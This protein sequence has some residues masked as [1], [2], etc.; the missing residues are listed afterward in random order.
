MCAVQNAKVAH[1]KQSLSGGTLKYGWKSPTQ[2]Y[3][4]KELE[5]QW[6]VTVCSQSTEVNGHDLSKASHEEAIDAFHKAEEP[7][8]V[9]VLRRSVKNSSQKMK[10]KNPISCTVATQTDEFIEN[11]M[12]YG[13]YDNEEEILNQHGVPGLYTPSSRIPLAFSPTNDMGLTDIEMSNAYEYNFE[14]SFESEQFNDFEYEEVTLHRASSEE[15][16]GL[17]LCYGSTD[18]DL[19]D[20]FISEIDP[21]SIAAQ[22]GRIKSGDQILQINGIDVHSRE[23]AIKLFQED[24]SDIT[25]LLGRQIQM[26]DGFLE[27]G[28][29][30]VLDDLH[31]DMLRQHPHFNPHL[32]GQGNDEEGATTDTATT[33]NSLTR[34]EKD[35]GVGRT[36]EST[37]NDE[38][39]E[40]EMMD[41][42]SSPGNNSKFRHYSDNS[43]TSNDT[44]ELEFRKNEISTQDCEKFREVLANR[45]AEDCSAKLNGQKE[46]SR[47]DSHSSLEQELA[48]LNKEMEHI[49]L[50]CQEI[51]DIHSNKKQLTI[52]GLGG[53]PYQSPRVVPRMGTRLDKLK[54]SNLANVDNGKSESPVKPIENIETPKHIETSSLERDKDT[55]YNTA[56]SSHRSTP[57]TLELSAFE[58][59]T[60]SSMLH[61]PATGKSDSSSK[62]SKKSDRRSERNHSRDG[63]SHSDSNKSANEGKRRS[64]KDRES[65]GKKSGDTTP[66]EKYKSTESLTDIYATYAEVMYTNQAN[67]AHTMMVQQ[68]LFEKKI[69]TSSHRNDTTLSRHPDGNK[70]AAPSGNQ[71]SDQ[72]EWV[73]KRRADGSRYVTRR[74]I[75]NKM[76]KERAKKIT[77]ERAGMTTDDDAMSEMKV[78]KYWSRE[79]RKRHLEKARDQ[80]RK[81]EFMQRSRMETLKE[82]EEDNK[83]EVNIV[84]LS[85]RKMMRHKGRKVFDDFTTVQEMLVHG[86]RESAGK[87]Y[88]PLLSVTTV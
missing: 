53:K 26:D 42:E 80:K 20:I 1:L 38:S 75:R 3:G 7:I 56:D 73:V 15:R 5:N 79:D 25:L 28:G 14:E 81:R 24:R 67:L 35:S 49:Q 45:Y 59:D 47:K 13:V 58:G 27:D 33:E 34:H 54:N 76:L 44:Q 64:R 11:E 46:P 48:L 10:S 63:S 51:I 61:L 70:S 65:D 37:K 57:L 55:A 19:T 71:S 68:K 85:H 29:N 8:V 82:K 52:E 50:E 6:T 17:T 41:N 4:I 78:G 40:Q 72:M 62:S 84:E 39:S 16:L 69:S 18:E 30:V 23:E 21:Y 2:E 9:E 88:N 66:Q 60:R 31:M 83:K 36:D 74:P 87:N 77:E 32:M 86:N 12:L 43:F 22:D